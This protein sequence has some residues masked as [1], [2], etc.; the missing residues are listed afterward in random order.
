[1]KK[2]PQDNDLGGKKLCKQKTKLKTEENK[3]RKNPV[4]IEITG[5]LVALEHQ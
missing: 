1:M 5:F 2:A 3:H 4:T